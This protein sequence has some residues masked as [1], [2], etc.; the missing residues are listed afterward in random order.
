MKPLWFEFPDIPW[1]SAGWRMGWGEVYW[2]N[3]CKWYSAL[4]DAE[5]IN[6]KREWPEISGWEGLY[7]FVEHGKTPPWILEERRKTEAAAAPPNDSETSI[8]EKYRV[9]WLLTRHLKFVRPVLGETDEYHERM[10]YAEP[11]GTRWV[12]YFLKPAGLRLER[13]ADGEE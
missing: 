11:T 4:T 7:A 6:Y 9:K 2:K 3:W 8:T 5:R 12:A 1:G 10:L 13:C